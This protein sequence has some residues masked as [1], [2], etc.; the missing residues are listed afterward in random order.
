MCSCPQTAPAPSESA[1]VGRG[2]WPM[3]GEA[4]EASPGLCSNMALLR[5][6]PAQ[7]PFRSSSGKPPS[8][9][10]WP[11]GQGTRSPPQ[12]CLRPPPVRAWGLEAEPLDLLPSPPGQS[13]LGLPKRERAGALGRRSQAEDGASYLLSQSSVRETPDPCGP[14]HHPRSRAAGRVVT[15]WRAS[16]PWDCRQHGVGNSPPVDCRGAPTAGGHQG[17]GRQRAQP[18]PGGWGSPLA[19]PA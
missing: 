2:P 1:E 18:R 7:D 13:V 9:R 16:Q 11:R 8:T 12:P 4:G 5:H 6:E 14:S 17:M 3:G 19:A 15:S 10:G